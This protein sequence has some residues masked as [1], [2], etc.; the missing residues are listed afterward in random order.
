M[1]LHLSGHV[2][3]VTGGS[4]GIGAAI[5]RA[6]AAE[7]ADIALLYASNAEKA[8]ETAAACAAYGVRAKAYACHVEKEE[9]A[10]QTVRDILSAFGRI[11]ILVNNAGITRDK[12]VNGM[13]AS[14]FDD[15]ID[16]NL[17]GAFHMLRAVYPLMA[18]QRSGRIL[19]ISSVAGLS[20]NAGQVNYAASK[21]GLIGMTKSAA[22]ELAARGV[23]CNA[24]A[25]GFISTDMTE[26]FAQDEKTLHAIPVRRMGSAEEVGALAAFLCSPQAAYI[27]GEVIRI[28]GGMM[29]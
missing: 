25:P 2:A 8:E 19:N 18:K 27:T 22:K 5:C 9:E 3:I 11:D 28:D 17:R 20:G 21:A 15:V 10:A 24:I 4:R 29:M 1:N 12:L 14:D 6:L 7:G 16:V 23:T 26:K 13:R